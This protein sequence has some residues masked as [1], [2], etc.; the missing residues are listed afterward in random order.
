[1]KIGI[2]VADIDFNIS[3][4]N[5]MRECL[6]LSKCKAIF[7]EPVSE[8]QNNLLL[9]RKS[10]PELY[11]CMFYYCYIHHKTSHLSSIMFR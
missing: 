6:K 8:K 3:N 11:E 2:K 10:I 5:D 4:V 1:M 7:F 9:L